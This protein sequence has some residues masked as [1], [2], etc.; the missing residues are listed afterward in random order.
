M[1]RHIIAT[2]L[3]TP[4][5]SRSRAISSSTR[6]PARLVQESHLHQTSI[7]PGQVMQLP[8]P[9]PIPQPFPFNANHPHQH[10]QRLRGTKASAPPTPKPKDN[11]VGAEV[12]L[13]VFLLRSLAQLQ[14]IFPSPAASA[15]FA[16]VPA[17]LEQSAQRAGVP[18]DQVLPYESTPTHRRIH[19][20][21]TQPQ[22]P[23]SA[24]ADGLEQEGI[25]TVAHVVGGDEPRVVVCSGFAVGDLEQTQILTCH[26]TLDEM[27]AHLAKMSTRTA[28]RAPPPSAT[29]VLT[30]SGHVFTVSHAAAS[31]PRADIL[32]LNLSPRPLPNPSYSLPLASAAGLRAR[33]TLPAPPRLRSLP[34][35]PYPAVVGTPIATL[36][37]TNPARKEDGDRPP[38]REWS[39]GRITEYKD[40]RGREAQ[41]GTYDQLALLLT[42][43]VPRQ[44]SSG[45]PIVDRSTGAVIGIVRGSLQ[46]HGDKAAQG[47]ATPAER[48]F[49]LFQLPGFQP[50]SKRLEQESAK[51]AREEAEVAKGQEGGDGSS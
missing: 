20:D 46:S 49:E 12:A 42:S 10:P 34:I 4:S 26:H 7:T 16:S 29:F 8:P 15:A 27:G 51:G 19:T 32:I 9:V 35:S 14:R 24:F 30:A 2:A 11:D 43:S 31:L 39:M 40:S 21:P 28:T 38:P 48:V 13:D 45:G 33:P 18:L 36:A 17:L 44:G 22:P 3:R 6:S 50:K 25:V 37:Y 41:T 5:R 47:F 1:H 23:P